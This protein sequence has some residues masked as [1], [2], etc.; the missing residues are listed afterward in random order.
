MK[1]EGIY[2]NLQGNKQPASLLSTFSS[3]VNPV[4]RT[5]NARKPIVS[6]FTT[7]IL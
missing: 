5:A 3:E 2:S 7:K 6:K 4:K 1:I